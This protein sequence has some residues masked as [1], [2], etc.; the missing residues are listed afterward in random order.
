[1]AAAPQEPGG[2]PGA[3]TEAHTEEHPKVFPPFDSSTY[4]SQLFWF[5]ITFA[6]LYLLVARWVLPHIGG[7][8]QERRAKIDGDLAQAAELKHQSDAAIAGY[9]K[10][11][12]E[13]RASA[14]GIAA[15]AR[16]KAKAEADTRQAAVE[17]DLNAKLAA[18]EARIGDIKKKALA[19]VG[20]IAADA[21]EAVVQALIG[22]KPEATEVA[23]AVA[24]AEAG[25][26]GRAG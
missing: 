10:A 15:Q 25:R 3:A 17:A 8:L 16:D 19:D 6:A 21:T 12:A 2:E 23:A 26:T 22:Q 24:G 9:E 7:I 20:A 18:A 1:M 11:L 14:T 5:V 4:A 13:A